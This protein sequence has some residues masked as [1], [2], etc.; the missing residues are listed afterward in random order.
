MHSN[1]RPNQ[2]PLLS[3]DDIT[4]ERPAW[5]NFKLG[6]LIVMTFGLIVAI[7]ALR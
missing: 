5:T 7:Y 2:Q 3:E 1:M 4:Y 6:V